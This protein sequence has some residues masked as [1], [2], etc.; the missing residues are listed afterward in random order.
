MV[1][2]S[3]KIGATMEKTGVRVGAG[4]GDIG[5]CM[6]V[7]QSSFEDALPPM[8]RILP[9]LP[10]LRI[11]PALPMLRILPALPILRILPELLMLR[12]LAKLPKLRILSALAM[13]RYDH[14]PVLIFARISR[15][16]AW[17]S[18]LGSAN[19]GA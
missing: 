9:A 11:L 12:M 2:C 1:S 3:L 19:P 16:I 5:F 18:S 4:A 8:V 10:I 13:L 15:F 7:A 14:S 17:Y 6:R